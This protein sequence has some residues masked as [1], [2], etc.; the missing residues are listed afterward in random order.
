MQKEYYSILAN[1]R[2]CQGLNKE[3][4]KQTLEILEPALRHY[5]KGEV[6]FAEGGRQQNFGLVVEGEVMQSRLRTNGE[7]AL[8]EHIKAGQL[9]GEI[10]MFLDP[11]P[12]WRCDV[13][14]RTDCTIMLF[15]ASAFF[16]K[17]FQECAASG[18]VV[19][20]LLRRACERFE[21]SQVLLKS[22]KT[23][24]IRQRLSNYLYEKYLV[25]G[26]P[27]IKLGMTRFELA[28]YLNLPRPSLSRELSAM[29][30][31]GIITWE[32][33]QID[34]INLSKLMENM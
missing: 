32:G 18:K 34:I 20:N 2:L 1:S 14:A 26:G 24:T 23:Q 4:C 17:T 3:E 22:L 29:R 11:K 33:D 7:R 8:F 28:E 9:F 16:G 6:L 13:Q 12:Y 10:M 25:S 19:Y 30:L 21:A 15:S 31:D 27:S 5:R